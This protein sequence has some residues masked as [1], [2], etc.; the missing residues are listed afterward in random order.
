MGG[1]PETSA[2]IRATLAENRALRAARQRDWTTAVTSFAEAAETWS[3][4]GATI[5]LVRA[6]IWQSAALR[7]AGREDECA[8]VEL[9]IPGL[10]ADLRTPDGVADSFVTQ[11]TAVTA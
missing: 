4:L 8:Q 2:E 5:W 9:P 1:A 6:L 11:L 10:L 3:T 7:G